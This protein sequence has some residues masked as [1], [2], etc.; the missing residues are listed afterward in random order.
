VLTTRHGVR[1]LGPEDLPDFVRLVAQDPVV[2]V[3][4]DYRARLTQLDTRWLGGE[5]WGYVEDGRLVSACHSAA[6]L[7]PVNGTPESL[8]AFAGRAAKAERRAA[9]ILGPSKDI[10]L[11]WSDLKEHWPQPREIRPRQPHLEIRSSPRVEPGQ[12]GAVVG[13][14]GDHRVG[15]AQLQHRGEV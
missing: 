7:V 1:V 12:P 2:N 10:D 8:A 13:E 3:F 4:A 5:M 14:H 15:G 9:T 6:N 11:L